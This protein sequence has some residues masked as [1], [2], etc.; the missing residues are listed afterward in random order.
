MVP[1]NHPFSI[2]K[3]LLLQKLRNYLNIDIGF[4]D[5]SSGLIPADSLRSARIFAKSSGIVAGAEEAR[6]LFED[7][8]V[9][10]V[11]EKYDGESISK[12][13]NVFQIEG[14]LR[15]ILMIE[16]TALD[17]L[18]ILSSIATSTHDLVSKVR[19]AQFPTIIATTR[20]VTPGF[21]W[22]EK[23][24]VFFGGGDTHRWN[25]SDMVM[26]KDTHLAFYGGDVSRLL[27]DAK[28]TISFSKKIEIELENSEDIIPAIESGADIIML[29]NMSPD[30]IKK[31]L[32]S[33]KIARKGVLFEASGNITPASILEYAQSGVDIIS[34][35]ST[36]LQPH[37]HLDYSLRL[38]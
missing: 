33:L 1:Q 12:G 16:R 20:K 25:L 4:G 5:L 22:F 19:A 24:A 15:N 27:L 9:Q 17:F 30:E 2:P 36:V 31:A 11:Q 29:D 34:T 18:M 3:P 23:K 21:G 7:L 35:S 13:E 37:K 6:L 10:V 14:N 38:L 32:S 26:F 8:G 28:K